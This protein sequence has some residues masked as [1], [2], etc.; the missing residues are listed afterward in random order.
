MRKIKSLLIASLCVG[1]LLFGAA[2][3]TGKGGSS[4]DPAKKVPGDE[5]WVD[6]VYDGTVSLGLDY[7]GKDFYTDGIG[8]FSLKTPI[9]GDTAHF[10]PVVDSTHQGTMKARFYGIDT[11]ESTGKVQEWGK[12]A[13]NFTKEKLKEADKNGTIVV[14]S[15]QDGYG[16]PNPDSTGSRYVSLVW[17]NLTKKNAPMNE[18]V[19]LNLWIVQEGLSWVKNVQS[20]PQYEDTFYAAEQQARDYELKLFSKE[21]DPDFNYGEYI[22]T[23]L[24]E[25]KEE[26]ALCLADPDHQNAYDNQKIRIQGTVAGY[27]NH[28]LYLQDKVYRDKDDPSQ[29]YEY[30]GINI[31]VGMG[32]ISSKYTKLNTFIQ[33]CGLAQYTEN[34]G[35]QITDTQGRFPVGTATSENDAKVIYTPAQNE[36]TEHN[37]YTFEYTNA[38]LSAVASA[39]NPYNL[40]NLNCFTKVT[41]TLTCTN[42]FISSSTSQEIT[43]SFQGASYNVY[44]PFNYYGD[45]TDDTTRW[46][47]AG[48]FE[49]RRF[50]VQG[51]YVLHKTTTGKIKFQ[52]VPSANSDLICEMLTS[53]TLSGNYKKTFNVG[54]TFNSEG[55]EVTAHYNY[56]DEAAITSFTVDNSKVNMSA[57]G[58]YPVVISYTEEGF[59]RTARYNITVS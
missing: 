24:L 3:C 57:A 2:A 44:V 42:A 18:L 56:K 41:E 27:S 43:L 20:M 1:A 37:L 33:V 11:P 29:G 48:D 14:S 17:I 32:S 12:A 21:S 34:Y 38:Q 55:L 16:A 51:V 30:C 35:F 53:I 26:L 39:D 25:M 49:G 23:S 50:Q 5:N 59:T 31:F 4:N 46:N 6:Y 13:S 45:P 15:A 40:E 52:I 54:E 9:D 22:D 47:K 8:Q 28:L 19:L 10:T 36:E 7:V 58:T